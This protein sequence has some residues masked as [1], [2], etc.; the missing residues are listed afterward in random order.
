MVFRGTLLQHH[1][2]EKAIA[3]KQLEKVVEEGKREF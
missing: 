1:G 3:V 2:G